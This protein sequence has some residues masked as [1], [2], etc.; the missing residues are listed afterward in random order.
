MVE[1]STTSATSGPANFESGEV[2][3]GSLLEL[4]RIFAGSRLVGAGKAALVEEFSKG[5]KR[6]SRRREVYVQGTIPRRHYY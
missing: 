5:V 1:N 4:V 3:K 6:V 2:V